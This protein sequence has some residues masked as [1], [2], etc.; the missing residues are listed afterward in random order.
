VDSLN[1]AD[2]VPF[3]EVKYV[4]ITGCWADS[5]GT[6]EFRAETAVK[7][8]FDAF[9][10]QIEASPDWTYT[11]ESK[12]HTVSFSSATKKVI[13]YRKYSIVVNRALQFLPEGAAR[14]NDKTEFLP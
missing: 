9:I 4:T 6:I 14:R 12:V 13:W 11:V 8:A 7:Q 3:P 2:F 1:L 10:K 5:K